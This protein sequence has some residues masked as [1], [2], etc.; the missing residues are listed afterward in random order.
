MNGT[1]QNILRYLGPAIM[2]RQASY[3]L[4]VGRVGRQ[5]AIFFSDLTAELYNVLALVTTPRSAWA[6]P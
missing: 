5:N 4:S 2:E 6:R 3:M 1:G